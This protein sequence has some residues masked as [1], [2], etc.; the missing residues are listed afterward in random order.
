MALGDDVRREQH[1]LSSNRNL[2]TG[3]SRLNV[4][5]PNLL[6]GVTLQYCLLFDM[7]TGGTRLYCLP[8]ESVD[9]FF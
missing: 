4:F 7:L 6:A 1:L 5:L 2:L 9:W 8:T 3:V